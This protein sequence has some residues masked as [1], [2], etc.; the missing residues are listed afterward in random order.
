MDLG[1]VVPALVAVAW[2]SLKRRAWA[3][4]VRYAAVGW[5][6][7]PGTAVTG[8]AIVMQASGDPAP[9]TANTVAFASFAAIALAIAVLVYRPLL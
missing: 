4:S 8:M 3:A 2:G 9:T 7:M 5:M 1:L 6:A